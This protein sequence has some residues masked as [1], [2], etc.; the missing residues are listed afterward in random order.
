MNGLD[1]AHRLK[2]E[3]AGL[4]VVVCSGYSNDVPNL[5]LLGEEAAFLAKPFKPATLAKV[6]RECLDQT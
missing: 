5:H 6:I 4:R 3:D 2:G 1:L